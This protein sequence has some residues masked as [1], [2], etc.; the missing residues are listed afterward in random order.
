MPKTTLKK[1]ILLLQVFGHDAISEQVDIAK[2]VGIL[3]GYISDI[4]KICNENDSQ[5]D[6]KKLGKLLK[7]V[8][9]KKT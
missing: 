4:K 9:R 8:N 5:T 7:E 2:R 6:L 1:R 3:E